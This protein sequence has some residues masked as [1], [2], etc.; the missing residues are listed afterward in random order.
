VTTLRTFVNRYTL[1]LFFGLTYILSWAPSLFEPHSLNAFGPL[2]SALALLGILS[3]WHGVRDFLRRLVQWRV[4]LKWYAL[5]LLLPLLVVGTTLALGQLLGAQ[6]GMTRPVP[7]A[8]DTIATVIFI[9]LYIG[10]GE[11]PAWRGFALPRLMVGRTALAATLFLGLLHALWHLPLAGVEYNVQ[12]FVPWL[13][14]VMSGAVVY[15]WIYQHT[16]G[17]LLLPILLHTSVN[18]SAKYL[19]FPMFGE[20]DILLAW[21]LLGA[22]WFVVAVIVVLVTGP[23]LVR[24]D[25]PA[26]TIPYAG[27]PVSIK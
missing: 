16:Q 22:L 24:R 1:V 4:G 12:N 25:A 5:V 3:G 6:V 19:F 15:T 20:A 14:M 10:L 23:N 17:N 21:W 26:G 13:I 9:L 7:P 18:V 2:V 8:G 11:E 27:E